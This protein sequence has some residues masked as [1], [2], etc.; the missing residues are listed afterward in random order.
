MPTSDNFPTLDGKEVPGIVTTYTSLGEAMEKASRVYA[1][2][3]YAVILYP[4]RWGDIESMG[5]KD[6]LVFLDSTNKKYYATKR[7]D[8]PDFPDYIY[9]E[10]TEKIAANTTIK[11]STKTDAEAAGA[12]LY[13]KP[14]PTPMPIDQSTR[15]FSANG[16][17]FKMILV[18]G[19]TYTM[20]ATSEQGSDAYDNEKPTRQVTLSSYYIGETEVTQELWQ[21][22]KGSNPSYFSG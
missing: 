22:V 12:T 15:T 19:G 18:D 3:E 20:G 14:E 9:Y 10:S 17:S 13:V 2:G 4:F 8:V 21:A 16:I 11:L 1:A 6:E 5:I 7:K